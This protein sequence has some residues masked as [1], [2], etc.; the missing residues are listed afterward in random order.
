MALYIIR[1]RKSWG[2]RDP[3]RSWVNTYEVSYDGAIGDLSAT[4]NA[5][6]NGERI[7]HLAEVQFLSATISTWQ[8]DSVPY[9]PLTF[10]TV[11]LEQVGLRA[12]AG[13]SAMDS[14]V[15]LLVKMMTALGRNGRRFY[16]GCLSEAD[17]QIGGDAKFTLTPGS[18]LTGNGGSAWETF[19]T[20]M[21]P[22]TTA[23]TG[24]VKICLVGNGVG[25]VLSRAVEEMQV[26]GVV[27]NRRNHRYYDL[28]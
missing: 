27:V 12:S 23:G 26:G 1:V 16:R 4:A 11:E 24:P 17:V 22:F 14:N 20:F 21:Q 15:C 10:K 6:A 19:N 25:G 18:P 28:A 2:A 7:L 3:E 8:P 5:I 13:V 9:N